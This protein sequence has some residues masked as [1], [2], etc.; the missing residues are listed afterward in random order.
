MAN[1][2]AGGINLTT[3]QRVPLSASDTLTDEDG[4]S[5]GGATLFTAWDA[6]AGVAADVSFAGLGAETNGR[7]YLA[8][9]PTTEENI[10]FRL[11]GI[12]NSYDGS[13]SLVFEIEWYAAAITGGVVWSVE[14]D[15][16]NGAPNVTSFGTQISS[17]TA[18]VNGTT[19][20]ITVTDVTLTN[21]EA[22][23]IQPGDSGEIRIRRTTGAG[24]DN[25]AGDAKLR[26]L[27]LR[28]A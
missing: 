22:N 6:S 3:G 19:N 28:L 15:R 20:N 5:V 26:S 9:D 4:N 25:M 12:S 14:V 10:R 16:I 13:A 23:G 11:P 1:V 21:A 2:R 8:F 24:G 17:A 27:R 18:T 7:H